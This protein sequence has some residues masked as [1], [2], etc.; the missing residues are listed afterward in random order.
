[1]LVSVCN[2]KWMPQFAI[3]IQFSLPHLLI[4]L[5]HLSTT[6]KKSLI[7]PSPVD[8]TLLAATAM[9]ITSTNLLKQVTRRSLPSSCVASCSADVWVIPSHLMVTS[10]SVIPADQTGSLHTFYNV[11]SFV[12]ASLCVNSFLTFPENFMFHHPT[13]EIC[14]L[15]KFP[16]HLRTQPVP[17]QLVCI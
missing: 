7:Q 14:P 6:C 17:F 9:V 3:F 5:F 1:M 10:G 12:S 15:Y 8:T 2:K 13:P 4:I 16:T 11:D